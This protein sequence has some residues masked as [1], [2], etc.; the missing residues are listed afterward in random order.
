MG[1]QLSS[2]VGKSFLKKTSKKLPLIVALDPA[3]PLFLVSSTDRLTEN[4]A[5]I[6]MVIHTDITKWGFSLPCGS[7]DVYPNGGGVYPQPGCP[8]PSRKEIGNLL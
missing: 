5:K 3:G 4:D 2:F 8:D 1:G 6:V 7:I